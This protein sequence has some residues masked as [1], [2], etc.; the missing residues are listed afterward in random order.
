MKLEPNVNSDADSALFAPTGGTVEPMKWRWHWRRMRHKM[1]CSSS[2]IVR[3]PSWGLWTMGASAQR[4]S[5]I[6]NQVCGECSGVISS[7]G[8]S[9]GSSRRCFHGHP[10]L[11]QY[12]L[13]EDRPEYDI[14]HPI[15]QVPGRMGKGVVVSRTP[16]GNIIAG[17]TAEDSDSDRDL[18]TTGWA[19]VCAGTGAPECPGA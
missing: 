6:E 9:G 4:C 15:F 14:R 11:G 3:C 12:V 19:Q 5:G 18:A 7:E 16:D 8:E 13:L 17:P 10:R 2:S 1:A